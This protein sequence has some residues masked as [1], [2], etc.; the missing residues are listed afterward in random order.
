MSVIVAIGKRARLEGYALAGVE[1]ID[2]KDTPEAKQA[3]D[4]LP[5]DVGLVLLD[6]SAQ[7]ALAERLAQAALL[8]VVV[9]E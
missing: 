6:R 8:W 9:P 5:P 1:V 3:W 2:A 7:A 4:G